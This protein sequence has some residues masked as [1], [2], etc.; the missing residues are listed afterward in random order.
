MT[1]NEHKAFKFAQ[2]MQEMIKEKE[3]SEEQICMIM[4]MLMGENGFEGI[5]NQLAAHEC[6]IREHDHHFLNGQFESE[7]FGSI[8]FEQLSLAVSYFTDRFLLVGLGKRNGRGKTY[9][10]DKEAAEKLVFIWRDNHSTADLI[11]VEA[12]GAN[13]D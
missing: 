5:A 12:G 1:Q 11:N 6:D 8:T 10:L 7:E 2:K 3:F 13:V 9:R 4:S